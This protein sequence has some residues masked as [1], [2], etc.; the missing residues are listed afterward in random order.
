MDGIKFPSIKYFA[1]L[2]ASGTIGLESV[3]EVSGVGNASKVGS[4]DFDLSV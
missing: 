1:S 2:Y 3:E 4:E